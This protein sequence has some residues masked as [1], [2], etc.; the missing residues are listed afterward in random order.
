LRGAPTK[1]S[2][3]SRR[4]YQAS[5]FIPYLH[6]YDNET[7]ITKKRRTDPVY[8]D[9]RILIRGR[10]MMKDVDMKKMVAPTR[11]F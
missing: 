4:E 8:Q 3:Y 10:R 6:H 9:R 5:E 11:L 2:R 1:N 7:L